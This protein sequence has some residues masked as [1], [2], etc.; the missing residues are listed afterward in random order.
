M[1]VSSDLLLHLRAIC[2]HSLKFWVSPQR[3]A[4][5]SVSL[6]W[7][8]FAAVGRFNNLFIVVWN[9]FTFTPLTSDTGGEP[10]FTPGW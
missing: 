7:A 2:S 3:H 9:K 6:K 5:V 10:I 1:H 8:L 4:G